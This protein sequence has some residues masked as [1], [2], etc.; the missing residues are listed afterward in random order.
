MPRAELQHTLKVLKNCS[1]CGHNQQQTRIPHEKE[2]EEEKKL[3]GA[4]MLLLNL[5]TI[6]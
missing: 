4:N 3:A 1:P 2:N 5:A 6:L